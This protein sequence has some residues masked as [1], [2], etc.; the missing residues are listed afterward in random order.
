MITTLYALPEGASSS[1]PRTIPPSWDGPATNLH[2]ELTLLVTSEVATEPD[3]ASIRAQL[4]LA[5]CSHLDRQARWAS[6]QVR[7]AVVTS[8]PASNRPAMTPISH[9]LPVDPPPP[10]TTLARPRRARVPRRRRPSST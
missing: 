6:I 9:A 4:A 8:S 1:T 3:V 2:N 7:W 10:R 5:T